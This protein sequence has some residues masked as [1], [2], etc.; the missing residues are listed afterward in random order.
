[1]YIQL[2]SLTTGI[3]LEDPGPLESLSTVQP[4]GSHSLR[5]SLREVT[6]YGAASRKSLSTVQPPGS[7]SLRCSLREVTLYGVASGKSLS[8]VQPPGSHSLWCSLREVTLYGAASGSH[9]RRCS[10]GGVTLDGAA[11]VEP[12]SALQPQGNHSRQF[13]HRGGVFDGLTIVRK[14]GSTYTHKNIPNGMFIQKDNINRLD[15]SYNMCLLNK[16]R[17]CSA[18][19][20]ARMYNCNAAVKN[21]ASG[22]TVATLLHKHTIPKSSHCNM[23]PNIVGRW[24]LR[25]AIT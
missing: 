4:P 5:C 14:I 10:L 2:C 25:L 11:S 17:Y 8:T 19:N 24:G 3:I 7:H 20:Y 13:S 21:V 12:L 18:Y 23:Q 1:M 6:L 16:R 22:N 15:K 9:S